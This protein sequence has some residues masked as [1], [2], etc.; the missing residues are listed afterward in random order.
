MSTEFLQC[1]SLACVLEEKHRNDR[2]EYWIGF[3]MRTDTSERKD[4]DNGKRHTGEMGC[5]KG[6]MLKDTR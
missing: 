5:G 1:L 4:L 3:G 2:N 6:T